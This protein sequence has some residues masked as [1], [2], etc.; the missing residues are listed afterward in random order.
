MAWTYESRDDA[1][2]AAAIVGLP[3]AAV[4]RDHETGLWGFPDIDDADDTS[5]EVEVVAESEVEI[6]D[7]EADDEPAK[8]GTALVVI[9][10]TDMVTKVEQKADEPPVFRPTAE[11][12]DA[13]VVIEGFVT[14][15]MGKLKVAVLAKKLGL[16]L[17]LRDAAT[18]AEIARASGVKGSRGAKSGE[19][20]SIVRDERGLTEKQAILLDM[21]SRLDGATTREICAA[22]VAAEI[23]ASEGEQFDEAFALELK[24]A[25]NFEYLSNCITRATKGAYV[26]DVPKARMEMNNKGRYAAATAH[27]MREV[28]ECDRAATLYATEVHMVARKQLAKVMA[29]KPVQ[30]FADAAD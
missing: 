6:M 24:K 9:G 16:T 25:F 12:G 13:Y 27:R 19:G 28:S 29:P 8:P 1:G 5:S 4:S 2:D 7:D 22:L 20:S 30:Q 17:V 15:A 18:G 21:A 3:T 23:G 11:D 10:G 26:T 14:P